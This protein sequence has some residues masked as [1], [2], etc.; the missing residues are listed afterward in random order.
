MER[1]GDQVI[2]ATYQVKVSKPYKLVRL[3][4]KMWAFAKPNFYKFVIRSDT[5][6][7]LVELWVSS[8]SVL[9]EIVRRLEHPKCEF[10]LISAEHVKQ[11][12]D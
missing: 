7:V 1:R 6:F 12:P 9:G 11:Q 5:D 2:K 8:S 3:L 10:K 4:D